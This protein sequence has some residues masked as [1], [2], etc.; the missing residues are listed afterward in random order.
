MKKICLVQGGKFLLGIHAEDILVRTAWAE[1]KPGSRVVQLSAL[2]ARQPGG[3]VPPEA[4]CL[5]LQGEGETFCL[6]ADRIVDE[7]EVINPPGPLPPACPALAARLCPQVTI[8][9]DTPVLLLDPTQVIPIAAELGEGIGLLVEEPEQEDEISAFEPEE[10]D[11][12]FFLFIEKP[13]P[14]FV[15]EQ[16]EEISAPEEPVAFLAEVIPVAA[17]LGEDIDLLAEE[18]EQEDERSASEP[19]EED[20]PFFPFIEKPA[21]LF[22]EEQAEELAAPEEPVAFLT[23]EEALAE[24]VEIEA[25]EER[26]KPI[27]ELASI[28]VALAACSPDFS[29]D[30]P[31]M[32]KESASLGGIPEEEEPLSFFDEESSS[33]STEEAQEPFAG[34]W[35]PEPPKEEEEPAADSEPE[36]EE[37]IVVFF[38]DEPEEPCT[39]GTASAVCSPDFSSSPPKMEEESPFLDRIPEEEDPFSL[40]DEESSSSSTEEAEEPLGGLWEPEPPK[41]K[42]KPV[43]DREPE[44]EEEIEEVVVFFDDEPE[45]PCAGGAASAVCSSHSS[46]NL[47]E[48]EDAAKP[49]LEVQA[50]QPEAARSQRKKETASTID[51]ET[52][53]KVMIWTIARFKQ[54]KAGEELRLGTDQL[55]PE[56]ASMVEQKGLSRSIIQYLIDQIVLRCKESEHAGRR[57]PDEKHVK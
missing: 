1:V 10:E 52:F 28:P 41:E 3:A 43:V 16:T 42:E 32:E 29:S 20:D 56:L 47:R 4:V 27:A 46:S 34:L 12:P 21:P 37:E 53:K 23:D 38:D 33:S 19:E 57:L 5:E 31:E 51:E 45:E 8:W 30:L 17:G 50:P 7:V 26:E 18:S 49:A 40:F 11:D 55:P 2:L 9:G 44:S 39:V 25:E 14:L 24:D 6:L 15:E 54:S 48:R 36:S 13:V 35:E 22:V